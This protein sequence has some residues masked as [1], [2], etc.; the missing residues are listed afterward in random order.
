MVA[1]VLQ[2]L[3][4]AGHNLGCLTEPL[5]RAEEARRLVLGI[6]VS[7]AL[8]VDLR[9]SCGGLRCLDLATVT[10]H[11]AASAG[12]LALM[13]LAGDHV[14]RVDPDSAGAALT[15]RAT[16][17]RLRFGVAAWCEVFVTAGVVLL[18]GVAERWHRK[19]CWTE[20]GMLPPA[21]TT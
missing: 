3:A 12:P 15:R 2:A 20:H 8:G 1:D 19:V 6:V 21:L 4:H 5:Q 10:S 13:T 16:P 11:S 14:L 9:R 17:P 7:T 18:S